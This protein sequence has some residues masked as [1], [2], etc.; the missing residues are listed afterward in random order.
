MAAGKLKHI[1]LFWIG[2]GSRIRCQRIQALD[3]ILVQHKV[4]HQY[5]V[6]PTR[7]ILAILA[8]VSG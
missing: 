2:I 6:T 7:A 4:P 3:A 5:S 8:S 1:G